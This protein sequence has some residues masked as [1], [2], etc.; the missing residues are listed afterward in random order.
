MLKDNGKNET[1]VETLM[2][3]VPVMNGVGYFDHK[4]CVA[5]ATHPGDGFHIAF[6]FGDHILVVEYLPQ[7]Y[8][9]ID[10]VVYQR[11]EDWIKSISSVEWI[12]TSLAES[13]SQPMQ[14]VVSQATIPE[15]PHPALQPD[16]DST[17]WQVLGSVT[18]DTGTL[19]LIDP[20]HD[21][22]DV[23][24]LG[25]SEHAQVPVPGGDFSAVLVG[26]GLGDGR[27]LVEGRFADCPFGRRIAEIR[28]RLFGDD[29]DYLGGNE[30]EP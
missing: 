3:P 7:N 12:A 15:I 21:G 1:K 11:R 26:T 27:Y 18:V 8:P 4:D 29:G 25:E 5:L 19:L 6:Q 16:P 24:T 20:V 17:E 23:G 9:A 22:V 10:V 14:H 2:L 30:E 13:Q 28:V